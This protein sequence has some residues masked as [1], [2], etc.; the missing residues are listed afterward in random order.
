MRRVSEDTENKTTMGFVYKNLNG[1]I[2]PI[3]PDVKPNWRISAYAAIL[4]EN[5]QKILAVK[6]DLHEKYFLPGGGIESDESLEDGLRRE[7]LEEAHCSIELLDPQPFFFRE[8]YFCDTFFNPVGDYWHAISSA[9]FAKKGSQ[10]VSI[11]PES[12]EKIIDIT[13]LTI[14]SHLPDQFHH[15]YQPMIEAILKR[16]NGS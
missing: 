16:L 5:R 2:V 3:P 7:C 10:S 14:D 6:S 4:S 1:E 9:F 11:I 8:S 15:F 13:W 12:P